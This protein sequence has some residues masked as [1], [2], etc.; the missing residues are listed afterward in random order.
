M[1]LIYNGISFSYALTNLH[2]MGSV[3]DPSGSDQLFTSIRLEVTGLLNVG[4]LPASALGRDAAGTLAYIRHLLTQPR[5]PLYYD[6]ESPP[7]VTGNNPVINIPTGRDDAGGPFPDA[8]MAVSVEYTT[9]ATLIVKWGVT[10]YL[11]DCGSNRV[12][13]PLSL[14][15]EDSLELDE[16]FRMTRKRQGTLIISSLDTQMIDSYRRNILAAPVPAGFARRSS[17][18]QISRDGLRCDYGFID[19]QLRWA[20]PYPAVSMEIIQSETSAPKGFGMRYGAFKVSVKGNVNASPRALASICADVAGVRVIAAKALTA[21]GT[22]LGE[23]SVECQETEESVNVTMT[24]TYIDP[25]SPQGMELRSSTSDLRT[26]APDLR[27][28]TGSVVIRS[29]FDVSSGGRSLQNLPTTSA[30]LGLA[31]LGAGTWSSPG[32][33]PNFA[34]STG[35]I[36]SPADGIMLAPYVSMYAALLKDPCGTQVPVNPLAGNPAVS[37]RTNVRLWNTAAGGN[38]GEPGT[39]DAQLVASLSN[40]AA[41]QY[42]PPPATSNYGLNSWDGLP[43]GYTVWQ[44]ANEYDT[45]GGN[46]VVPPCDPDGLLVAVQHSAPIV[47]LKKRWVAERQG[48]PPAIPPEDVGDNFILTRKTPTFRDI[49]LA[50]NGTTQIFYASGVYEYTALDPTI[51]EYIA[52]VAPFLTPSAFTQV[53]KWGTDLTRK[54][55]MGGNALRNTPTSDDQPPV[56][57]YDFWSGIVNGSALGVFGQG[58]GG[59]ILS[60]PGGSGATGSTGGTG[61]GGS[62]PLGNNNLTGP[63]SVYTPSAGGGLVGA[64]AGNVF[65]SIAPAFPGLAANPGFYFPPS[66]NPLGTN[67]GFQPSSPP[68]PV[69]GSAPGG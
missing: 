25:S 39:Y 24:V 28:G 33:D 8:E 62:S 51:V 54:T 40:L 3:K 60:T 13:A 55:W 32:F 46:V 37:I 11:R 68:A 26:G 22:V 29:D 9:P 49:R 50:P 38:G 12:T 53:A 59:A 5:K 2:Q 43:G 36:V 56:G 6:L 31:W 45:D 58:V 23:T 41:S 42:A 48:A 7:G 34:S 10:T 47:T 64:A 30:N 57:T 27:S 18:Y 1:S 21:Q 16:T 63:G 67:P 69:P 44:C 52:E 20:P 35:V 66:T 17:T 65:S 61:S 14:R 19:V 15:W 4:L